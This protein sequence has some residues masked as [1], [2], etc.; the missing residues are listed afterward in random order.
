MLFLPREIA[1]RTHN[2]RVQVAH[3]GTAALSCPVERSSIAFLVT[4]GKI[5]HYQIAS[6]IH[7]CRVPMSRVICETWDSSPTP[8][9]SSRAERDGEPR[10]P[11]RVVEGSLTTL[12][13]PRPHREFLPPAFGRS[14]PPR[15]EDRSGSAIMGAPRLASCA[16]SGIPQSHP[17]RDFE[18]PELCIRLAMVT[19]ASEK[20]ETLV[21]VVTLQALRRRPAFADEFQFRKSTTLCDIQPC[22]PLRSLS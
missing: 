2:S 8:T 14:P 12:Q 5:S 22:S 6:R 11:S 10:E 21:P 1:G 7:N 15:I 3:V 4:R 16:R 17:L 18:R 19:T 9:L 13:N 20:V